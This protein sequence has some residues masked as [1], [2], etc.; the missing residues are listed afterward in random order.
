[1]GEQLDPVDAKLGVGVSELELAYDVVFVIVIG[2]HVDP[3][4]EKLDV[5]DKLDADEKLD[6]GEQLLA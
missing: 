1:V 4:D 2:E 3:V 6:V 5:D